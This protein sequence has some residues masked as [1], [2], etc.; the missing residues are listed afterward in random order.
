MRAPHAQR[1]GLRSTGCT[2]E[3]GVSYDGATT[4][5]GLT[6]DTVLSAT[7]TG[8]LSMADGEEDMDVEKEAGASAA[9]AGPRFVVKKW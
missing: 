2:A 3:A 1:P 8:K 4:Q 5:P 9:A 7:L 6:R